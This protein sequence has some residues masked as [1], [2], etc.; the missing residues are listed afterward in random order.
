MSL[1]VIRFYTDHVICSLP[2]GILKEKG[3]E[4]FVPPLPEDKKAAMNKMNFGTVD[5]IYLEYDKPFL[6][7]EIS[8]VK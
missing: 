7:P 1:F 6:S 8:E 4:L 5:K 3:D 2:L